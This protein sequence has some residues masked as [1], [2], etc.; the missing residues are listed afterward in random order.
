MLKCSERQ[1][2]FS[3]KK[4]KIPEK[5]HSP[6]AHSYNNE[7]QDSLYA[8]FINK[9]ISQLQLINNIKRAGITT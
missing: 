4:K 3:F 8:K 6:P 1:I 5:L 7:L 2:T 9:T